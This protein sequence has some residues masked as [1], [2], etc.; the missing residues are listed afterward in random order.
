VKFEIRT[1]RKNDFNDLV[2]L[3]AQLGYPESPQAILRRFQRIRRDRRYHQLFVASE[4]SSGKAKSSVIGWIHAYIDKILVT[5]PRVEIGGLVVD[6]GYRGRGVGRA[7]LQ[8]AEQWAAAKGC[9]PVIVHT[10]VV[11][12]AAHA[13]YEKCGYDLL[14]QQKVYFKEIL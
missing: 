1:V 12:K 11:R 7:L 2:R 8:R 4:T 9:S 10:N 5:G 6:D 13:F 3:S 14:K